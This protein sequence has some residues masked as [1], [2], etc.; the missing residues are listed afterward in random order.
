[1]RPAAHAAASGI[2]AVWRSPLG[3]RQTCGQ[4]RAVPGQPHD[5]SNFHHPSAGRIGAV[6]G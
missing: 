4:H 6:I 1:L 3:E 5:R 2:L